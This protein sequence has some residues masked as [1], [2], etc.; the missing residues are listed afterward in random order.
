MHKMDTLLEALSLARLR[1]VRLR[2]YYATALYRLV[3]VLTDE[4][5]TLAVDRWWR[6]YYNAEFVQEV[7]ALELATGLIHEIEHLLR[8]HHQRCEANGF[9]AELFNVSGDLEINDGLAEEEGLQLIEGALLPKHFGLRDDLVAEEY[10]GLLKLLQK[11]LPASGCG[12]CAHGKRQPGELGPPNADQRGVGTEE[13]DLV[14][15]KVADDVVRWNE[16]HP[17]SV[18]GEILRWAQAM[19]NPQV[20]WQR[21]LRGAIRAHVAKVAGMTDYTFQRPHRRQSLFPDFVLPAM[22][23]PTPNVAVVVD[24]SGS[25]GEQELMLALAEIKGVLRSVGVDQGVTVLAV[26]CAVHNVKR[27]FSTRNVN[28]LGGGGTDMGRGIEAAAKLRPKPDFL[29]IVT[30]GFTPWPATAPPGIVPIVVLVADGTSPEWART[31]RVA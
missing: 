16:R 17:G 30:D 19:L 9:E 2:P 12:S 5:P 26:D 24:T 23:D 20:P 10:Y 1:A 7:S 29:V 21:V 4:L 8:G 11:E 6:L 18:P 22:I 31:I 25:M 28:L 3:P 14:R 27:V 15:A 13:N